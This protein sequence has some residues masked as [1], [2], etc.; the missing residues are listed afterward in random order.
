MTFVD[1]IQHEYFEASDLDLT[2]FFSCVIII[3]VSDHDFVVKKRME[4]RNLVIVIV[5]NDAVIN[6]DNDNEV[7]KH[8]QEA[9]KK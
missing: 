4:G 5:P 6:H 9:L 7:M 8:N 2:I 3:W 1:C